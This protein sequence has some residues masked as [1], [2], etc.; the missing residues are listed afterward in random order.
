MKLSND[1]NQTA[2]Q[3]RQQTSAL[4]SPFFFGLI[5][6]SLQRRHNVFVAVII[7]IFI[8]SLA[9]GVK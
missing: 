8:Y 1:A 5:K 7:L 9:V 4:F 6:S 3:Q 2:E